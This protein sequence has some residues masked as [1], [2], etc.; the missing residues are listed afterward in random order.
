MGDCYYESRGFEP[1]LGTFLFVELKT[2]NQHHAAWLSNPSQLIFLFVSWGK[3]VTLYIKWLSSKMGH[4][5]TSLKSLTKHMIKS[6]I[7]R[8]G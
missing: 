8:H 6:R 5:F 7:E 2:S 1:V 4:R 3:I